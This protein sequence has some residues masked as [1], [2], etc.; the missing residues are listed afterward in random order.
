MRDP[1]L[2]RGKGTG[3]RHFHSSDFHEDVESNGA[4]L[5]REQIYFSGP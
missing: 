3:M 1:T 5:K 4:E 2:V